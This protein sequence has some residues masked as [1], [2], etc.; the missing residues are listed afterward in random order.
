M[1]PKVAILLLGLAALCA[2]NPAAQGEWRWR[3]R[4]PTVTPNIKG[5]PFDKMV[6]ETYKPKVFIPGYKTVANCG[7]NKYYGKQ[8]RIV[9]GTEA[10]PHSF[11]WQVALFFD[12]GWFCGGSIID[13]NWVLTAAHC[14][15]GATGVD[16]IAGAHNI[17]EAESTQVTYRSTDFIIHESWGSLLL[18]N[19]ISVIRVSSGIEFTPEIQP[20]CLPTKAQADLGAGEMVTPSGWGLTS[21]SFGASISPTLN[22]VTVPTLDNADCEAVY[23]STITD[24]I[25]CIDAANGHGTCSGDSG[26]PLNYDDG[27]GVY[28]TQG[29]TSFGS[30]AGCEVGYPDGFTR[31]THYLEWIETTTGI[32]IS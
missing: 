16:I 22:E 28:C 26:G 11:P 17:R 23:G 20:I 9:G 10:E 8:Q 25:V 7:M 27:R 29:V 24:D 18:R 5:L 32:V 2:A 21:D 3:S 30:S 14:T 4:K 12:G 13:T 19:D 15:D 31:L 1:V 6:E